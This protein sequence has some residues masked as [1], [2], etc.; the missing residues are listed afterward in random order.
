[1]DAQVKG[2]R[3]ENSILFSRKWGISFIF[4]VWPDPV[5]VFHSAELHL[6]FLLQ[7]WDNAAY[8]VECQWAKE[9]K[10]VPRVWPS[11]EKGNNC[12]KARGKSKKPILKLEILQRNKVFFSKIAIEAIIVTLDRIMN[13]KEWFI[14]FAQQCQWWGLENQD[15]RMRLPDTAFCIPVSALLWTQGEPGSQSC[16]F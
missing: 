10:A 14:Q 5:L 8:L 15:S 9:D 3:V 6:F 16:Y 11:W 12:I 13:N 4:L 2:H 1:M 7:S